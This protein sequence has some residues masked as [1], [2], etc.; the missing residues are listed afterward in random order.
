M[1]APRAALRAAQSV[2]E[3]DLANMELVPA[4]GRE[5]LRAALSVVL[6]AE[7]LAEIN[8]EV[9]PAREVQSQVLSGEAQQVAQ[10]VASM[11]VVQAREVRNPAQLVVHQDLVLEDHLATEAVALE[12]H[13]DHFA[14]L[15]T[16]TAARLMSAELSL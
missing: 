11:A 3:L 1:V 8:M 13:L 2:A 16:P 9:A 6:P 10:A 14:P 12:A 15:P 5:A 7:V 4:K